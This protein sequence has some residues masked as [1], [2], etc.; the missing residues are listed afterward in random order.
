VARHVGEVHWPE[1]TVGE[2]RGVKIRAIGM[3]KTVRNKE[4]AI[5]LVV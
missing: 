4:R 5:I 3:P 1:F 2:L